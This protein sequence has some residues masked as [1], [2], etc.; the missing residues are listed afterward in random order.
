[1]P[2]SVTPNVF[3]FKNIVKVF[4]LMCFPEDRPG[5]Q[6]NSHRSFFIV[7][8]TDVTVSSI[9]KWYDFY[10]TNFCAIQFF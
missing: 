3:E 4:E 2:S 10:T 1:M 9:P 7:Q 8:I 5:A 6:K